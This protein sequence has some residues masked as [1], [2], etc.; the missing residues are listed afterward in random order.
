MRN[1]LTYAMYPWGGYA[2]LRRPKISVAVWWFS[3][4]IFLLSICIVVFYPSIC[5]L[6]ER[7]FA[8]QVFFSTMGLIVR[9]EDMRSRSS[10]RAWSNRLVGIVLALFLTLGL[11]CF[12]GITILAQWPLAGTQP[13]GYVLLLSPLVFFL[14]AVNWWFV[15]LR[16]SSGGAVK[17]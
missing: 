11:F 14:L 4:F 12:E 8:I 6:T 17:K 13:Q 1:F 2:L 16:T 9:T 15:T 7:I 5:S 10:V 3:L